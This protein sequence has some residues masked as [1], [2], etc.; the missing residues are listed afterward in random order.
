LITSFSGY[1]MGTEP[2]WVQLGD[3][4]YKFKKAAAITMPHGA[5][6]LTQL[7]TS[8]PRDTFLLVHINTI[9]PYLSKIS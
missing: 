6:S 2:I 7:S 3:K 9:G 5:F 4:E 1:N 8:V